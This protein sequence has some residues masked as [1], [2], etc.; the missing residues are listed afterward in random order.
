MT[1]ANLCMNCHRA[2]KNRGGPDG[3]PARKRS[4]S[5]PMARLRVARSTAAAAD[6]RLAWAVLPSNSTASGSVRGGTPTGQLNGP[7]ADS[8]SVVVVAWRRDALTRRNIT[9]VYSREG[10]SSSGPDPPSGVPEWSRTACA[11]ATPQRFICLV[12]QASDVAIVGKFLGLVIGKYIYVALPSGSIPAL[13]SHSCRLSVRSSHHGIP[14]VWQS[15]CSHSP[16]SLYVSRT[17]GE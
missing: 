11:I 7:P 15:R 10:A 13:Q 6:G 4:M 14:T 16:G 2:A 17:T 3:F 9:A 8:R 12:A 5:S 1:P